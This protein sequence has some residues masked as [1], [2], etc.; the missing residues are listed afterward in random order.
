MERAA[1][2]HEPP[3]SPTFQVPPDGSRRP[4]KNR[5]LPECAGLPW[6]RSVPTA[7]PGYAGPLEAAVQA[8]GDP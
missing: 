4:L 6:Q 5:E 2:P 8:P 1:A 3:H 7:N